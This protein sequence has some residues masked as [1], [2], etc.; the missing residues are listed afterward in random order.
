MNGG[1]WTI[2]QVARR[3]G[4]ARST[5]LHYDAVGLLSP[6]IRTGSNYRVYGEADLARLEKIRQYRDAGLSLEAIAEVLAS[7]GGCLNG[8]LE[9]RLFAINEEIRRLKDQQRFILQLLGSKAPALAAPVVTKAMWVDML[10][11]AG[12]DE[13]GMQ[14]WHREFERAAPEGHQELLASLGIG[15]DEI[16]AIRAWSAANA[17]G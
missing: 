17:A 8:A 12:L 1:A 14:R 2:G 3:F 16:A 15:T 9:R 4:L 6:R 11:A 7:E 13:G 10:R 5:L